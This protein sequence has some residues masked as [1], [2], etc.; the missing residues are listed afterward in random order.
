MV[1]W[2]V[3]VIPEPVT[4]VIV[5]IFVAV[6]YA[7]IVVSPLLGKAALPEIIS[8]V[9]IPTTE[10]KVIVETPDATVAIT[11]LLLVTSPSDIIEPFTVTL[12]ESTVVVVPS[13]WRFPL[14]TTSPSLL[15]PSG[16]GSMYKTFPPPDLVEITFDE[17]PILSIV[18][19]P[20]L[21]RGPVWPS[22]PVIVI[23]SVDWF[24]RVVLPST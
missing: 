10:S 9:L 4:P 16:Y 15:N 17:I 1:N 20:V 24:P 22:T 13:T 21:V 19:P 18:T 5:I 3:E 7:V 6:L 23:V 2:V 11:V 14:T 12:L 8:P